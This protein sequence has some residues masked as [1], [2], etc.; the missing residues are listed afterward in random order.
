MKMSIRR[1]CAAAAL[2]L[3][4]ASGM[5]PHVSRGALAGRPGNSGALYSNPI[6]KKQQLIC[7]PEAPDAGSSSVSYDPTKS[8]LTTFEQGPGFGLTPQIAV[9]VGGSG[10]QLVPFDTFFQ[11]RPS[12]TELGYIQVKY[13]FTPTA[14]GAGAAAV[15]PRGRISPDAGFF[16]VDRDAGVTG[17]QGVDTFALFFDP[18]GNTPPTAVVTYKIFGAPANFS[19]FGN[20]ADFISSA[21][22]GTVTAT[23]P[24]NP[25]GFAIVSGSFLPEPTCLTL[26]GLGCVGLF[27][28]RRGRGTSG[29]PGTRRQAV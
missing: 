11:N 22:S 2:A 23:E 16:L 14:P 21:A 9:R 20:A 19:G 24:N 10:T 1:W 18:A 12:Y 27:A 29:T 6:L 8:T 7:D 28:R 17:T 25:I 4:V 3:G 15:D 13:Q 5:S 26:V